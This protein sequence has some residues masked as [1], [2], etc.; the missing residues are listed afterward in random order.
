VYTYKT[1]LAKMHPMIAP[2]P[3]FWAPVIHDFWAM[4][5]EKAGHVST[6]A[7]ETVIM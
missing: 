5:L 1:R 7:G 6:V 4:Q 2:A 3:R